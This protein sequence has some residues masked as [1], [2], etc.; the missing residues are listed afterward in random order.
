VLTRPFVSRRHLLGSSIAA[1]TAG[2]LSPRPSHAAS[3]LT[4]VD[5]VSGAN[6]QAFW[7]TY[8]IPTISRKTGVDIKY[9]VGS[10]PPLQ[11]QMQSWRDGEPGFSL[12]FLKDL[13]LANMVA[14]A[15]KFEPLYPEC[16]MEIPNQKRVPKEYN[17]VDSGVA[18][19]GAGL[20]F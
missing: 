4:V 1:L 3:T 20:L 8:L 13:D 18:L 11:L 10:G 7:K 6:F 12:M 17:E 15:T 2:T 19:H 16:E 5:T 14:A 9:T